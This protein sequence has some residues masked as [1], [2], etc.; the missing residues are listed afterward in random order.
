MGVTDLFAGEIANLFL[1]KLSEISSSSYFCKSSAEDLM[2]SIHEI[3]P[4]MLEINKYYG[5]DLPADRRRQLE[6]FSGL[7]RNGL[8]LADEVI[9]SS[10][11]NVFKNLHLARR[12]E[13]LE[14][15]VSKF[16]KGPLQVHV[17]ADL[18]RLG[19]ESSKR[20]D[21]L[22]CS[23]WRVENRLE[24]LMVGGGGWLEEAVKRVEDEERENCGSSLVNLGIAMDLGKKRVKEMVIENNDSGVVGICGIGGSG[25]TT[26][27][28][29]IFRDAEVRSYFKNRV[30]FVTVSQS[31]NVEQLKLK[32]R[33]MVTRSNFGS[34][35]DIIPQW[36]LKFDAKGL[37]RT[38]VILD[39]VWALSVLEQLISRIPGC[40]TLVVSRFKFPT[41][42]VNCT[43]ELEL[44]GEDEA[45]SL[46]CH[47]AFG[48]KSIPL[49]ADKKLIKQVV[50]ECKGLPLAL[51]VIG[52]SLR[53]QPGKFW[54]S[55]KNRL[56]RC[57][58]ICESHEIQ[59]LERMKLSIDSL[60]EQ[61]RECFLDLGAFPED[62]KIPLDVLVNIWVELHG[63]D[64]EEAFAILVE[65]SDKNLISLVKNA[66]FGDA[67]S[68][69]YDIYVSQ[70]DVLRD[71]AIYLSSR[72]NVNKRKRLLMPRRETSIPRE[73]EKIAD[74]PFDAQIISLHTGEMREMDWFEGEFPKAEV[75][76]LNFSSNEYFLPPFINKMPKLRSLA[77]I[78]SGSSNAVLHNLSVFTNLSNLRSLW[79]EKIS[80]P[81]LPKTTVPLKNLR[82]LSLVLCKVNNGLDHPDI[83]FPYLFPRL[84]ELMID[85]CIDLNELPQAFA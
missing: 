53:D 18:H 60:P 85:H 29:E 82:K 58:P 84:L 34:S 54:T 69:C 21:R 25:K 67:Y 57:Q 50:N 12:M 35:G 4:A 73:W 14:Q 65:L 68:S 45:M 15:N 80:V 49:G 77:L 37:V 6:T 42:V 5:K 43:Y 20:F 74:E 66:R 30:L 81:Q 26:L 11:W 39:D 28:R 38:L 27:A 46:F 76:I 33:G 8:H 44:L 16:L 31:P 48:Q 62:R 52:A 47:S 36:P 70:H 59:L 40:K 75:V 79:F 19:F 41:S 32:I 9:K 83:D 10:R 55:A 64:K 2:A 72:V 63:I 22:E 3:L 17:L 71:L 13:K 51:K 61:V 56:S 23:A 1:Q 24:Y 7:L 78:N